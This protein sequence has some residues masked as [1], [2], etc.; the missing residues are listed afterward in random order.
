MGH[1]SI[2]FANNHCLLILRSLLLTQALQGKHFQNLWASPENELITFLD[3]MHMKTYLRT[4]GGK[5]GEILGKAGIEFD[6][7]DVKD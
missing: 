3:S 1:L 7:G 4:K 6:F 5:R 2:R